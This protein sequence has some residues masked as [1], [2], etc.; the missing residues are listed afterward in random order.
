MAK[1]FSRAHA[2]KR[3]VLAALIVAAVAS[4]IVVPGSLAFAGPV[5]RQGLWKFERTLETAGKQTDRRQTSGLLIA[6]EVTRCV[7]PTRAMSAEFGPLLPGLC[8]TADLRKEGERYAF[9]RVCGEGA[10]VLTEIDVESDSS[11]K[12]INEGKIGKMPTKEIV[13]AHRVGD[14]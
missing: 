9:K 7:N 12:E 5:F 1:I 8:K 11:Y 4:V 13:V 14:C 10:P 3:Y 6:K 2:S